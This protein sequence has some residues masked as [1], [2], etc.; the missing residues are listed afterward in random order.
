MEDYSHVGLSLRRHSTAFLREDLAQRRIIPWAK[1]MV[2]RD[3]RWCEVPGL[4][5]VRQ[6]PDRL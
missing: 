1:V 4:A 6:R 2:L 3:R 5:L